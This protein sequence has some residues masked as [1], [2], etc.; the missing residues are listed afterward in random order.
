MKLRENGEPDNFEEKMLVGNRL[1]VHHK[2][3]DISPLELYVDIFFIFFEFQIYVKT[4]VEH[5]VHSTYNK[6]ICKN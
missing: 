3:C 5:T 6:W 2:L 4:R 1:K